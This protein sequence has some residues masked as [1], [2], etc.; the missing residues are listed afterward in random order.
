MCDVSIDD[1]CEVW[2]QTPRT[3]R[4]EHRCRTC[5]GRI[6]PGERYIVHFAVYDGDPCSEKMCGPCDAAAAEFAAHH[7]GTRFVPSA[8][9]E[10][11]R[12]CYMEENRDGWTDQD[13][14]WRSLVA[15]MLVRGR[16]A[17]RVSSPALGGSNG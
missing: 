17:R 10:T 8:T 12:D 6:L 3:A 16:A 14:R 4:K 2:R 7:D 11:L 9:M 5:H 13:R 15:G 1:V